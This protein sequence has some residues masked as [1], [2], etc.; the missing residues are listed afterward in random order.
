[1]AYR[2]FYTEKT[3]AAPDVPDFLDRYDQSVANLF[4]G[5]AEVYN[6]RKAAVDQYSYGMENSKF[7]NDNK[8]N[9]V[10]STATINKIK[11]DLRNTGSVS[12]EGIAMEQQ[13]K[14]YVADQKAQWEQ[15][16]NLLKQI[17]DVRVSDNFY[18]WKF[19]TDKVNLAAYGKDGDIDFRTRDFS[20]VNIGKDPM[21]FKQTDYAN[22]YV[23][24]QGKKSNSGPTKDGG[25][26]SWST[27]FV[28]PK[29]GKRGPT[30]DDAIRY[31]NSRPDGMAKANI[32]LQVDRDLMDTDV[33]AIK[34]LRERND[35]RT[36]WAEGMDDQEILTHIKS[37]PNDN[38]YNKK[39]YKQLLRDKAKEYLSAAADAVSKVDPAAKDGGSRTPNQVNNDHISHTNT[40]YPNNVSAGGVGGILKL[41]NSVG[42]QTDIEMPADAE[43]VYDLNTGKSSERKKGKFILDGYLLGAWDK[44]GNY[45][46]FNGNSVE[47]ME[48]S[49][50]NY[51]AEK[52][53]TLPPELSVGLIGHSIDKTNL[54]GDLAD[55][56]LDINTQLGQARIKGDPEEISRLE[57]LLY[58]L[59]AFSETVD[60]D[61][62]S[63]EEIVNA[64]ASNGITTRRKDQILKASSTDL[65]R[66]NGYTEGLNLKNKSSWSD[67]MRRV[68][69][70]Y[71]KRWQEA[72][73]EVKRN[74]I[75]YE[76]TNPESQANIQRK[77]DPIPAVDLSKLDPNGFTKE[78]K[79]WRYKD[80]RLFDDN[81]KIVQ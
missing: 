28:D 45:A 69:E 38:P 31:F 36:S 11:G 72:Q 68:N 47:E 22:H 67:D 65:D 15:Y 61:G 35:T 70:V 25:T 12:E 49:I 57:G 29:T 63:D 76:E 60:T 71:K 75:K 5:L 54:L 4:Q 19:D 34:Q 56:K 78:G 26:Y 42:K 21:A 55:R 18:D 39:E 1:M 30:D 16:E 8:F 9:E 44:D 33:K 10:Y 48:Q 43:R 17:N 58:Q 7:L 51:P 77:D 14:R 13:G 59:N 64:A 41:K 66:I 6:K 3:Y 79:Y 40:F 24:Q 80:G 73:D 53:L 32:A 81:G 52:F 37:N 74:R 46:R 23:S 2:E 27:P 62:I 20:N 50:L